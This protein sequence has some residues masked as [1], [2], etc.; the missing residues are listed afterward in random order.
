VSALWPPVYRSTATILIEEQGI[1][2]DLVRSTVTS[3]ADERIQVITQQVMTRA[4]LIQIVE[5]YDLYGRER[6]YLSNEEI[7][8]RMRRDVKIETISAEGGGRLGGR[9][10]TIAFKL[11]YDND[12][13]DQ[14]QKVANELVTL[15][16]NE[17]LR[18]RRQRSEETSSFLGDEAERLRRQIDEIETKLAAFKRTNAGRLPDLQAFNMQMRDRAESELDE[19]ARQIRLL[20][21]RKIYIES[22]MAVVKETAPIP[23]ERILEPD[24]RLRSLRNQYASQSGVYAQSHPDLARMRREIETLE[25]STGA[26]AA[27]QPKALDD[28]RNELGR[29]SERYAADHPDVVQQRKRVAALEAERSQTPAPA[30]RK[31]DNPAY[32][33]LAAQIESAT[34][35]AESLRKRSGELRARV[36][37]YNARLEQTP[38]VEQ[39]YRDLVRDHESATA[40]YKELRSKQMEA[41]VSQTLEKDR[42]GE[43]FSL[44]DPP[45]FPDRPYKPNRPLLLA[46]SL[47]VALGGGAGAAGAAEALDRSVKSPRTLGALLETPLLGVLPRVDNDAQRENRRRRWLLALG[48]LAALAAVALAAVHLFVMPLDSL[49]YALLRRLQ[50]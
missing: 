26:K 27:P 8:E 45:Q 24:E 21:D 48:T 39:G 34:R 49:W 13:A 19:A 11:S 5:K 23:N 50:F 41:Q 7:L 37:T 38:N 32:V 16:L 14:A 1:P 42:K 28:A 9:G 6:R 10:T 35:E 47:F 4:T 22:Q 30:A 40:K 31:P 18:T 43:R 17:N 3:F 20:E 25:K 46:F 29:L 33:S 44:I 36:A 15:Y 12:K 2:R